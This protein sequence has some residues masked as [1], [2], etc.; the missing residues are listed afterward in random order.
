MGAALNNYQAPEGFIIEDEEDY[1]APKGFVLEDE[2]EV[3]HEDFSDI[4]QRYQQS[5]NAE[6]GN[7]QERFNARKDI[8]TEANAIA[9]ENLGIENKTLTP[10]EHKSVDAEVDRILGK[11]TIVSGGL[12]PRTAQEESLK[13][14]GAK[15]GARG[16][17]AGATLDL[18]KNLEQEEVPEEYQG[19][20][21]AGQL[22]GEFLPI[23]GLAKL[24]GIPLKVLQKSPKF[25]RSLKYFSNVLRDAGIGASLP[26]LKDVF[27]G[28]LPNPEE[29][30]EHAKSWA[31]IGAVLN[32]PGY[33]GGAI[34]DYLQRNNLAGGN[35][36]HLLRDASK[37]L[38]ENNVNANKIDDVAENTLKFFEEQMGPY[39]PVKPP[40]TEGLTK[41]AEEALGIPFEIEGRPSSKDLRNSKISQEMFDRIEQDYPV[42]TDRPIVERTKGVGEPVTEDTLDLISEKADSPKELGESVQDVV[43]E[44][45]GAIKEEYKPAYDLVEDYAGHHEAKTT[46]VANNTFRRMQKLKGYSLTPQEYANTIRI[47]EDVLDDVGAILERGENGVIEG[48][49]G[50]HPI[51]VRRLLEANRRLGSIVKY[52][53]IEPGVR[54]VLKKV[55][56]EIKQTIKDTL[57]VADPDAFEMFNEAEKKFIEKS[58]RFSNRT[59]WKIR[60]PN[61]KGED[62]TSI[63]K[64]PSDLQ[65]VKAAVSP[66]E[67]AKIE[68]ELLSEMNE[69]TSKRAEKF[70]RGIRKQ[71]SD[72][73]RALADEILISKRPRAKLTP[74]EINQQYENMVTNELA[75]PGKSSKLIN[76]WRDPVERVKIRRALKNNPNKDKIISYLQRNSTAET[77]KGVVGRDGVLNQDALKKVLKQ[78]GTKEAL[79][80]LGGEEA[81]TFFEKLDSLS[82]KSK[83]NAERFERLQEINEVKA[84]E[85]SKDKLSKI[86]E[87]NKAA[88]EKKAAREAKTLF[89]LKSTPTKT[90]T[91]KGRAAKISYDAKRGEEIINNVK[92]NI[93]KQKFP[94]MTKMKDIYEKLGP[95]GKTILGT[96][97]LIKFPLA[98]VAAVVGGEKL[99]MH[100]AENPRL[101]NAIRK[102]MITRSSNPYEVYAAWK[103][104]EEIYK[105]DHGDSR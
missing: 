85:Y 83:K 46:N 97:G 33:V 93:R 76:S 38:I 86:A 5:Y 13:E 34:K 44:E 70:Y 16:L 56:S 27:K 9:R 94:M 8:Y 32:L 88:A 64:K 39:K 60:D 31:T 22:V 35:T 48:L 77:F 74:K 81:V 65:R 100:M 51:E 105:E 103:L 41:E 21:K 4:Q 6:S 30:V 11:S 3:D 12:F 89:Q 19:Y 69:M 72:D 17:L 91:G 2:E 55:R 61:F 90:V 92:D 26:A 82:K 99:L 42:P 54:D 29:M 63:I 7:T 73:A 96:V 57:E 52:D 37:D 87:A 14:G 102:A 43:N 79:R 59:V 68:R 66:E 49:N 10:K 98:K 71:M 23:T 78:P 40:K 47:L 62:I 104:A 25:A 20:Y 15:Y 75:K 28:E 18:S 24:Y 67:F 80:D 53:N 50:T 84:S 45:L 95:V 101:R 36:Y 1:E 58:K